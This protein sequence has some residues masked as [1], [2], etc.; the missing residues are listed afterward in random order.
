MYVR[1]KKSDAAEVSWRSHSAQKLTTEPLPMFSKAQAV[2]VNFGRS[3]VSRH[4]A[5]APDMWFGD[6]SR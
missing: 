5:S 4:N 1:A 6:F 2:E 3:I